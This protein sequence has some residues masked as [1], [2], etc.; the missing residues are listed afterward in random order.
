MVVTAPNPGL[1]P[2]I[3]DNLSIRVAKYF[4]PVGLIAFNYYRNSVKGLF[5]TEEMSAD[6][7]GYTGQEY[8]GYTFRTTRTVD[9]QSI[10]IEGYELEFN[11]SLDYLPGALSGLTV[12][13]SYTHTKPQIPIAGSAENFAVLALAYKRGPLS[14]N[15]NTA[16]SGEKLNS[17]TTGSF[18]EP[19]ISADLSGAV[20]LRTNWSLFFSLR[21]LLD[22]PTNIVL[23]GVQTSNGYIADHAGDFREYGRSATV[24]L[25]AVF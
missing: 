21:N 5:Q 17:V 11:H 16:W 19:R 13:G 25:R 10:K 4:E 23:P 20:Q 1:E 3:S 9:G 8:A 24:G 7:F 14:L 15:L 6:E 22:E 2:E 12:R 18:I